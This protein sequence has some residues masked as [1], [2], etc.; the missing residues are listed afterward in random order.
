MATVRLSQKQAREFAKLI[1][2]DIRKYCEEHREEFEA[3]LQEEQNGGIEN[4]I[5]EHQ[6]SDLSAAV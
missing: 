1:Y 4:E 6:Q 5:S 2:S 3:F